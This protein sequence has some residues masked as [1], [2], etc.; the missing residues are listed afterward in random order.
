MSKDYKLPTTGRPTV[1]SGSLL[2]GIFIGLL[3]GLLLA[4]AVAWYLSTRPSPF[5]EHGASADPTQSKASAEPSANSEDASKNPSTSTNERKPRF[6]FYEILS[7]SKD[8]SSVQPAE[9]PEK[10]IRE[11]APAKPEPAHAKAKEA[12]YLQAGA[13]QKEGDADNLRAR[14]ALLGLEAKVESATLPDKQV[15][16]RVRLGPYSRSE[17]AERARSLLK[18]NGIEGN[19]IKVREGKW[20]G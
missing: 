11:S 16:H 7:G 15:W 8:T 10:P 5:L 4:T 13:F 6:E 20:R 12:Y 1:R 17:E 14:L 3:L 2:V 9:K 19:L 18:Q